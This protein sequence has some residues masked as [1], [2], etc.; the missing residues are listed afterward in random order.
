MGS[1]GNLGSGLN[2]SANEGNGEHGLR[3]E[4]PDTCRTSQ[5]VRGP[6]TRKWVSNSGTFWREAPPPSHPPKTCPE[7]RQL[8]GIS[9]RGSGHGGGERDGRAPSAAMIPSP[10]RP[11]DLD[12]SGTSV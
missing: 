11:D 1:R 5:A 8:V 10:L 9:N 3:A 4:G 6:E 7:L 2:S 12:S